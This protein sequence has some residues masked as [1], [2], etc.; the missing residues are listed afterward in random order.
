MAYGLLT[1]TAG[2]PRARVSVT[3]ETD[4][5]PSVGA[6]LWQ[7]YVTAFT[8][9]Q[10]LALLNHLY[11]E[12]EF[13]ALFFD[14]TVTKLIGWSGSDPVGLAMVTNNLDAVPQISPPFLY[15]RYPDLAARDAIFFGILVFV[16]DE[17]RGRTLFARL[18]SGMGQLA[19]HADGLI[20]FDVCRHNMETF[21]LHEQLARVA[22]WFPR[23]SFE[24]IDAQSYFAARFPLPLVGASAA[25]LTPPAHE[26]RSLEA[27]VA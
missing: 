9:L 7:Q 14:P 15:R 16:A 3:M 11:R 6:T 5:D 18:I 1:G 19:A 21:A 22:T 25:G 23:S 2:R 13:M 20:V 12:S 8:P 24:A 27:A 17:R 10:E 4:P 26:A